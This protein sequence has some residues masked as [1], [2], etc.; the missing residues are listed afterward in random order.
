M[1]RTLDAEVV[2]KTLAEL[3]IGWTHYTI[4][5]RG[6]RLSFVNKRGEHRL[7]PLEMG[8]GETDEHVIAR[9]DKACAAPI[10]EFLDI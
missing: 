9:I 5:N 6:K 3:G 10:P 2:K 8:P 1:A 4:E 7:V